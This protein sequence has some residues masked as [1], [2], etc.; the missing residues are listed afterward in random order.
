VITVIP[1]ILIGVGLGFILGVAVTL[2]TLYCI[3]V[4]AEW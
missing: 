2:F 4:Y 3:G 1:D